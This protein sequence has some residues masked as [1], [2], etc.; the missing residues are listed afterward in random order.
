MLTINYIIYQIPISCI[1]PNFIFS[2]IL[3]LSIYLV[4][5]KTVLTLF[6]VVYQK[7]LKRYFMI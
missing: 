6:S 1:G 4:K 3:E 7:I 5:S 2:V